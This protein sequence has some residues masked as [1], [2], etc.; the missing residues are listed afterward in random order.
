MGSKIWYVKCVVKVGAGT[1]EVS[2]SDSINFYINATPP[3]TDF[4]PNAGEVT[5]LSGDSVDFT[6]EA[7]NIGSC[8]AT[9]S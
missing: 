3:N 2:T 4:D 1:G 6:D 5:I 9:H 7:T 8:V